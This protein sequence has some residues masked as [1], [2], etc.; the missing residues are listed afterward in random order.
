[1]LTPEELVR[2]DR[3][4]MI[5]E[6]GQAGQEKLKQA[7]VLI[8]GAGGLGSAVTLY[9]A[10]AG[11]GTIRLADHD[12]VEVS[13]L[14]R[15]VLHWDQD[16]GRKKVDSASEKLRKMNPH[17]NL[18]ILD[19]TI[20]EENAKDL[21]AGCDGI[22]DAM[23]NLPTRYILNR[24]AVALNIP[25]FH[26]A[27]RGLEGRA[28]TVIPGKSACLRCLY[29]GPV[30][31]EKFPVL[32]ATPA[33]IGCI[34]ATEVIKYFTGFGELLVNRLLIYDGLGLKF[35]EFKVSRNA[36]CE[37]CAHVAKEG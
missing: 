23:D 6:I 32:G 1:M 7:T 29:R 8:A 5:P 18:E 2:Y 11:V 34:Q 36:E 13:N 19:K 10:A 37:H 26:G 17:V 25:F 16:I 20:T 4:I 15:Q 3:Q 28:M 9:L 31:Q 30:P 35:T 14:N 24:T 12:T 21:A 22:V 33:V 27:V